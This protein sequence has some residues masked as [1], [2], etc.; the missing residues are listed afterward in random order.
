[1]NGMDT[2]TINVRPEN[3]VHVLRA[4]KDFGEATIVLS[5][6]APYASGVEA[7]SPEKIRS[8][9]DQIN[10]ALARELSFIPVKD[11]GRE[12]SE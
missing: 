1:M 10:T 12:E 4:W 8:L 5:L 6:K 3:E 7:V 11:D 2:I 9:T